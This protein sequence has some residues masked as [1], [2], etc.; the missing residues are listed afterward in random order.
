M[1]ST[2]YV[3]WIAV[4]LIIPITLLVAPLGVRIAHA[5]DKRKLET[6]FGIFMIIVAARFGW[7]LL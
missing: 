4:L 6:A 1:A 3:N 7:S 5:L 2:G